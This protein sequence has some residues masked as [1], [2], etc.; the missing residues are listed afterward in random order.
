MVYE[1]VDMYDPILTQKTERFDFDN[2]PIDPVEL[3]NNMKDTLVANRGVGLAC[4]QVGLPYSMFVVGHHSVPDEIMAVFNPTIVDYSGEEYYEEEGCLTFPGLFIKV[5][6][7]MNVRVRM[8]I[9]DG[10]IDTITLDGFAARV[11]QHEFD[12]LNGILYQ[13]RA[14]RYHVDQAKKQKVKLDRK[15]NKNVRTAAA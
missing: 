6:R 8:A 2:P 3:F 14:N 4:P 12:H 15:R 10:S 5:K 9:E 11:F 7:H 13:K 1:L